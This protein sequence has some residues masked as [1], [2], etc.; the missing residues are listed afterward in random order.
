MNL[1]RE[2]G[3]LGCH[4]Y[5]RYAVSGRPL[6]RQSNS[7]RT[8]GQ[9]AASYSGYDSSAAQVP[10][11]TSHDEDET[12]ADADADTARRGS[13]L[14]EVAVFAAVAVALQAAR[15]TARMVAESRSRRSILL[16]NRSQE[17]TT[18]VEGLVEEDP[19]FFLTW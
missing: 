19:R 2:Q 16:P 7:L 5:L 10:R 11:Y 17:G 8:K 12:A 14:R 13:C 18:E 6:R 3:G 1:G 15:R 9:L 4:R